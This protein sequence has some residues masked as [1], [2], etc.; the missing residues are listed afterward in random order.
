M[1]NA[2]RILLIEDDVDDQLFFKLALAEV[3][4]KAECLLARHGSDGINKLLT[5]EEPPH[6]VFLDLNMPVMNGFECLSEIKKNPDLP[7]VPIIIFS[8]SND[9]HDIARAQELGASGYLHKPNDNEDLITTLKEIYAV[10][11]EKP[12]HPFVF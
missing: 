10:D 8:T 4:L 12:K 1:A 7:E 5:M 2:K 6:L 9:E 11:F 3:D